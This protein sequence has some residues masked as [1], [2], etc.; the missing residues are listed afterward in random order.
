M[1]Q[2][3]SKESGFAT[4]FILML[5]VALFIILG[6]AL[7]SMYS[8]NIQNRKDKQEVLKKVEQLNLDSARQAVGIK[9]E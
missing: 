1:T 7:K 3:S 4:I 6:F 2:K 9:A 5:A 8:V